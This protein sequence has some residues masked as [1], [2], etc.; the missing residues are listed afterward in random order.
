MNKYV[1]VAL[2]LGILAISFAAV[3]FFYPSAFFAPNAEAQQRNQ[4]ELKDKK[5]K[6]CGTDSD[7]RNKDIRE[8]D[9]IQ[10]MN[11][12]G[13]GGGGSIPPQTG[14]VINVYFHVIGNSSGFNGV[15]SQ[16]I[17]AQIGERLES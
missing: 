15:S 7:E 9:F 1:K 11:N 12:K 3:V 10:K 6:I 8:F 2:P 16:M 5:D 4:N 14:G 13:S 17:A